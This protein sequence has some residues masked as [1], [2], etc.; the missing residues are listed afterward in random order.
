MLTED[1]SRLMLDNLNNRISRLERRWNLGVLA[2]L[3]GVGL[4]LLT[5]WKP[6]PESAEENLRV[7][8]LT[9]V[10]NK[11]TARVVLGAPLPDPMMGG[12]VQKR[13][14]PF[15]GLLLNDVD[16]NERG[17]VGTLDDGTMTL[18]FDSN[19]RERVCVFTLPKGLTGLMVNDDQGRTRSQV[20]VGP[21]GRPFLEMF[22]EKE[23]PT[24]KLPVQKPEET[25]K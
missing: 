7:H 14:S 12:K 3:L 10:D 23:Q 22:D 25:K 19:G 20:V 5:G 6:Q 8:Q 17:G 13:R 1:E 4:V 16:G 9:V 11:G 18:C 15:T 24:L 21:E 2:C